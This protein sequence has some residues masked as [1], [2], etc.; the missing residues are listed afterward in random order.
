[1]SSQTFGALIEVESSQPKVEEQ[2][3]PAAP[4]NILPR[5]YHSVPYP[6][7]AFEL[8]NLQRGKRNGSPSDP[9]ATP[10]TG[11][12]SPR[13]PNDPEM[14]RPPSPAH[15]FEVEAMQSFSSPPMNRYR[16]LSVCMIQL[17]NGLNDAAPGALIPY[18]ET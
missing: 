3:I 7:D 6:A 8:D 5:V 1:M 12:Q 18:M 17:Q 11:T 14:S 10:P 13:L 16:M 2:A 4:K 9:G 15:E